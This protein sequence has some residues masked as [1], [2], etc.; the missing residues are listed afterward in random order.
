MSCRLFSIIRVVTTR[1]EKNFFESSQLL[2]IEIL[3]WRW[4]KF[5][6]SRAVMEFRKFPFK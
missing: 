6:R 4:G 3:E 1:R 5:E 2:Y